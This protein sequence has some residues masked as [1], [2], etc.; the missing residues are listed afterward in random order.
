MR[1]YRVSWIQWDRMYFRFFSHRT[2]ALRLFGEIRQQG[3]REAEVRDL[4]TGEVIAPE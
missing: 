3:W 4:R 1:H 2:A